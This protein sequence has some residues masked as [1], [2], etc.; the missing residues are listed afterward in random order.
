MKANCIEPCKEQ[1]RT[2]VLIQAN[3]GTL[4]SVQRLQCLCYGSDVVFFDAFLRLPLCVTYTDIIL[5][6][7]YCLKNCLNSHY[8]HKEEPDNEPDDFLKFPGVMQ[9]TATEMWWLY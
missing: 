4:H 3:T 1:D 9:R 5:S 7:Q 6:G 8:K 2:V